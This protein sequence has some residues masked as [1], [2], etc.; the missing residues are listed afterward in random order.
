VEILEG[1]Q[2]EFGNF[3]GGLFSDKKYILTPKKIWRPPLA[4]LEV[5]LV[6]KKFLETFKS[7]PMVPKLPI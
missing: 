2:L 6:F 5:F 1:G 7:C 3:T 4:S